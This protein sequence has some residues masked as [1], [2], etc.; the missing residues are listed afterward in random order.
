VAVGI[1]QAQQVDEDVTQ[2]GRAIAVGARVVRGTAVSEIESDD[3]GVVV[4][5]NGLRHLT[6]Q[7]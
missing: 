3:D 1:G 6:P 7:R 4:T 2:R 5:E